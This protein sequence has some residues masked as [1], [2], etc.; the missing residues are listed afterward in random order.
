MM[1]GFTNTLAFV[2]QTGGGGGGGVKVTE[3][4]PLKEQPVAP[5]EAVTPDARIAVVPWARPVIIVPDTLA[6]PELSDV[7]L[8]PLQPDGKMIVDV[9]LTGIVVRLKLKEAPVGQTR[10]GG[11]KGETLVAPAIEQPVA[12]LGARRPVP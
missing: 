3:I 8:P 7:K 1:E 10:G 11:G 4:D 9:S 2:G 5:L 6:M 12:P